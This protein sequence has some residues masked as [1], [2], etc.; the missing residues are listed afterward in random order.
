MARNEVTRE[1]PLP[2]QTLVR[3]S[4]MTPDGRRAVVIAPASIFVFDLAPEVR[5]VSQV[6]LP[7]NTNATYR[8]VD[9]SDDGAF[10]AVGKLDVL[11]R[12]RRDRENEE[13]NA[14]VV[15]GFVELHQP[16]RANP[17]EVELDAFSVWNFESPTVNFIDAPGAGTG[18][19]VLVTTPSSVFVWSPR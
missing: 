8:T 12:A 1:L 17:I 16:G 7:A 2:N 5:L 4:A 6:T 14:S 10:I 13:W 18:P 9:V 11:R 15:R 3:G 19:D